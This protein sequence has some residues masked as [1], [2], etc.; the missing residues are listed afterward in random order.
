MLRSDLG[1]WFLSLHCFASSLDHAVHCIN[2]PSLVA[3]LQSRSGGRIKNC[4]TTW[5]VQRFCLGTGQSG[6]GCYVSPCLGYESRV[7]TGNRSVKSMVSPDLRYRFLGLHY[8]ASLFGYT[9]HCKNWPS[10]VG[11][12]QTRSG[13][14]IKNRP[15]TWFV[16]RFWLETGR[17]GIGSYVGPCLGY[18]SGVLRQ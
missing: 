7:I 8:S 13:A 9:V 16:Q 2:W 17:S 6:I 12:L 1:Y 18:E 15:A 10:L 5:L 3:I 11:T 14:G 4:P